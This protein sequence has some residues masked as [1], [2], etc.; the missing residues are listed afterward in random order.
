VAYKNQICNDLVRLTAVLKRMM[1]GQT[2]LK[3]QPLLRW[4]DP[5]SLPN[6][7]KVKLISLSVTRLIQYTTKLNLSLKV[8]VQQAML[9]NKKLRY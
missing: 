7:Y 5:I 4:F 6:L 2:D 8:R 1:P 9:L 3:V